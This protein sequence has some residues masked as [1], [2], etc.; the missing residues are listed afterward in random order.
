MTKLTLIR[1]T[2]TNPDKITLSAYGIK[3][4]ENLKTKLPKSEESYCSKEKR[5][6]HTLNELGYTPIEIAALNES[7]KNWEKIPWKT[8]FGEVQEA[9]QQNN[10]TKILGY[11]YRN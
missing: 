4:V 2:K 3:L 8:N 11:F 10:E 7:V 6:V 9:Y 1:H 5:T